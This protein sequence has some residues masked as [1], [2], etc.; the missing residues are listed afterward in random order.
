MRWS[1]EKTAEIE[2]ENGNYLIYKGYAK[3]GADE[4]EQK[5]LSGKKVSVKIDGTEYSATID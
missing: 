5:S 3:F 1:G 4:P 2:V